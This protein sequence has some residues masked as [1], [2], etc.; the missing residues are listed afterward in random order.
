[1]LTKWCCLA[2]AFVCTI[3]NAQFYTNQAFDLNIEHQ[4]S[5]TEYGSGVS[6]ADINGDGWDDITFCNTYEFPSIY[7]NNGETFVPLHLPFTFTGEVK[8]CNWVDYDND[9]LRDL[10]FTSLRGPMKVYHNEGDLNFIDATLS[11]GLT[12]EGYETHGN[13][14]CDYDRDGD[15]DVYISNY[16][17]PEFGDPSIENFLYA[18]N[19]D[20]TFSDV[21]SIAGVGDGE[22]YTFLGIWMNVNDDLWPDLFISNDR[23]ESENSLYLNNGDGTFADISDSAQINYAILSMGVAADDFDNDGDDDL[24]VAN[25][26][27]NLML[28]NDNGVFNNIASINGTDINRFSWGTSFFDCDNDGWKDLYVA[29]ATH[30]TG[31]GQDQLLRNDSTSFNNITISSGFGA[32]SEVSFGNAVADLNHDG[33]LDIVT[34]DLT[35]SFSSVW[36]NSPPSE[37]WI[38]IGL[39]GSVSNHDGVGAKLICYTGNLIQTNVV[40]CGESFLSQNSFV[41]HF[42]L[43]QFDFADS[44]KVLWPSGIVDTWYNVVANQFVHLHEGQ[45]F[46]AEIAALDA[47]T[48]C[49]NDSACMYLV[50][51]GLTLLE[52]SNGILTDTLLTHQAGSYAAFV[53]DSHEN[54]FLTNWL[55]I[56]HWPMVQLEAVINPSLC[57]GDSS[58]IEFIAEQDLMY[59]W[60]DGEAVLMNL[61]YA[62]SAGEHTL[63]W[64][65]V[66]G[67]VN[68]RIIEIEEPSELEFNVIIEP[69]SCAGS[70]DGAILTEVNGGTAPY[71]W[72]SG[73][74]NW[75]GLATG[76]Y[77]ILIQDAHG[78]EIHESIELTDPNPII[79]NLD[80]TA[81][82]CSGLDNGSVNY[83]IE[84]G[85]GDI[86]VT[87]SW[88]NEDELNPG[89]HALLV[90]DAM[91]CEAMYEF[92]VVAPLPLSLNLELTPASENSANGSAMADVFGGTPPYVYWWSSGIGNFSESMNLIPD[93]YT[94]QVFDSQGCNLDTTFSIEST[95][96]VLEQDARS[97]L[98]FPNPAIDIVHVPSK[99]QLIHLIDEK[100]CRIPLDLLNTNTVNV[101]KLPAGNYIFTMLLPSGE[102]IAVHWT[103]IDH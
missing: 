22:T 60:L 80:W 84:G 32:D 42:G 4:L 39:Q 10:V 97:E 81:P 35:P 63:Q 82:T 15:L 25:W 12:F 43:G 51:D 54:M 14:W 87:T 13:A 37:N 16:N 103:K 58:F 64:I 66:H 1:M 79:I 90:T 89:W 36:I 30:F 71:S 31:S 47:T 74:T 73:M 52:W 17:G 102:Y 68:D 7:L 11:T 40:R 3:V 8:Q 86:E 61:E 98:V 2:C 34:L 96:H 9:G 57:A 75:S 26:N 6:L 53:T 91:G 95:V 48:I 33:A 21:T 83:S 27:D 23:F 28:R 101:R 24:Y 41:E 56:V 76:N 72:L 46:R 20:G 65:D 77:E 92:E 62:V 100:G 94:L 45:G 78:C 50:N 29:T 38:Q 93:A 67:C 44:L 49:Q 69:I 70:T 19:G 88:N 5:A 59:Y 85:M 18:N 55:E 99:V